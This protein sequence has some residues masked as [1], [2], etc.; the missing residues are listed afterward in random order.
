MEVE[1]EGGRGGGRGNSGE[2]CSKEED[3][4]APSTFEPLSTTVPCRQHISYQRT[5]TLKL[6][7]NPCSALYSL[8]HNPKPITPAQ[9]LAGLA[10]VRYSHL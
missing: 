3:F 5:V 10:I 4:F 7:A 8:T 6:C 1:R 2:V 9:R